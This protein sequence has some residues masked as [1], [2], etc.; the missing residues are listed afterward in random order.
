VKEESEY[1]SS[2]EE[3]VLISAL[4]GSVT[5]GSND[6]LID[7]GASKHMMKFQRKLCEYIQTCITPQSETWG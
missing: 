7:R 6:W 3:Y 1:S 5:R 2:D 4:T